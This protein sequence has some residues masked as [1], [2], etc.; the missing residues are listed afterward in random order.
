MGMTGK[1][2]RFL[3][4]AGVLLGLVPAVAAAQGTIISGQVTGTG[5]APVVGANVSISALR[6]GGF[7]DDQGRY[8]FAVPASAT[9]TT[10]TVTARR[11]GFSPSSAQVTLTGTAVVQ[12]FSITSA[13]NILEG[14]VVTAL[15]IEREKRS[16]G[17]SVQNIPGDE[18]T[19]ARETNIVN[20]L[21]GKVSG[22]A[23]TNAGSQGGSSRLVIRG[24]NSI[25][26][27]NQPLFIVDGIPVSN[28]TVG[29]PGG[30]GGVDYGNA[31]QDL[32]G[33]DIANISILK[34]PNA[35]ALYGSRAA[36]GAVVI[37][38]RS[39]KG[40][41]R[42]FGVSASSNLTFETPLRL[43]DY[44][45]EYGQG[46]GGAFSYVDGAGG[47]VND[48]VDESW[49]PKFDGQPRAQFF[50]V[51][52]WVAAPD[53]V[54][55]FF[56]TGRTVTNNIAFSGAG[57]RA[58]AR[59]S[60]TKADVK[61]LAPGMAL[62]KFTTALNAGAELGQRFSTTG[63]VQYINN[64]GFNR[65]GTGYANDNIMQQFVWFGRQ[66]D[67]QRLKD[68]RKDADGNQINWNHNYHD[69]PYWI[70]LESQNRDQKDRIIGAGALSF[71]PSS[72]L[73][74]TL[75]SG[76]DWFRDYRKIN[77]AYGLVESRFG[78]FSELNIF[79]Q[80]TNTEG[81]LTAT[82]ALGSR[83][84]LTANFGGNL[85]KT[86]YKANSTN[87]DA[88]VVPGIYNVGNAQNTPVTSA[89]EEHKKVNSLYGMA[90][91][92]LNNYLF[93]DVTGRNDWSSTLPVDGNS[94]FYPSVSGSF[95][96]TDALPA[97]S[98]SFLQYGKV[99][100][101]FAKV[102]NDA[103]PYQLQSTYTATT[104]FGGSPRYAVPNALANANLKP[105]ET[106]AFEVGTELNF[107]SNRLGLDL[108]FY[109]KATS[110][111]IMNA[112]ISGA[113]G[114][115]SIAVNAGKISNKGMDA[116]LTVT[117]IRLANGFEW[118]TALNF[119]RNRSRVEELHEDLQTV[120][121]GTYWSLTVEARKGEPYGALIGTPYR[122][123]AAGNIVV[124]STTG[125]PLKDPQTRVLGH[126][127]PDW[128][129]GLSN[130]LRFKGLDLSFLLD[131]H[132][133]GDVFSVTNM[134]GLYSG[135]LDGTLVGRDC[136]VAPCAANTGI[137]VEGVL[138]NGSPNTRRTSAEGYYHSLYGLH[139]A[140]VFD[141]TYLKLRELKLGYILPDQM[142][143]RMGVA[144]AYLALVGRNLWLSTKV[145]HIDPE[146][147][148][149]SGNAQ[150]LEHG[151][152]PS[153]RS[154]GLNFSI[155]P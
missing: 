57:E 140:H 98:G 31:I 128:T 146:T 73:T 137:L 99:R 117:P 142:A 6:V 44:Q 103:S 22:V 35:A 40:T 55:N 91:L 39:G 141:A 89:Y 125:R 69:N 20:S 154:I 124:S 136:I 50:G 5:G 48:G 61:G 11:L 2:S 28:Q 49:G 108:T 25:A 138:A 126:Y 95:V 139:E 21:S 81:L 37:T 86:Q 59:L 87:V 68:P 101:S 52:P 46:S 3:A 12:N 102:G 79:T 116:L 96:F 88:L 100:A 144:R 74:A 115:T 114:Y 109:N 120:T 131:K 17:T 23:I 47:G 65:N 15:G 51:G 18:I 148:F 143:N 145:P 80:E 150:G 119:S 26:G 58:N 13:P 135:V 94:Y 4:I 24:A 60:F 104:P 70:Q 72:W 118:N 107:F 30:F 1:I 29:A 34:G 8:N 111:Q 110:N 77:L 63:S 36:N 133:G 112:Q 84:A 93:V 19:Q 122:R 45:N 130:S 149:N 14:V 64:K 153:Q 32:N 129:A 7:T 38:T 78:A 43:P 53:N 134:F 62:K 41:P 132:K 75:R 121:L 105:E 123:D 92:A 97:L 56:E 155:T 147:A 54:R 152:F 106:K 67:V 66:V 151:Q 9:G 33:N 83:L 71:R 76:T 10:V 82:R 16:V 113:T 85:R 27:N 42:G 90:Q 127:P